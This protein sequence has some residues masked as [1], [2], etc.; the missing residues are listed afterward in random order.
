LMFEIADIASLRA[1]RSDGIDGA[2][3]LFGLNAAGFVG[4]A[5][6]ELPAPDPDTMS[7]LLSLTAAA[8]LG[9]ALIRARLLTAVSGHNV[10]TAAGPTTVH[11]GL[12][13]AAALL[14]WSVDLRF[15]DNRETLALLLEAELFFVAGMALGD[16]YIR[17]IGTG[18]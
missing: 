8:Y 7:T 3:S 9:S 16:R 15:A 13:I 17:A 11:G 4:A 14:A 6:L 1:R 10:S 18:L 5:L 12:A 2:T